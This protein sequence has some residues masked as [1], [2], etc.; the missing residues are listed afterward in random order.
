MKQFDLAIVGAGAAGMMAAITASEAGKRV[1]LID[2]NPQI[3]RKVL[4]TG[5][6]RCNLTNRFVDVHRY[7]G[8]SPEFIDT[9]LRRF[10]QSAT[11][12]FFENL[13]LV[14]KEEDNGRIFP[15][16]NQAS[17]VV[18]AMRLRLM[19]LGVTLIL[20]AQVVGIAPSQGWDVSF[21]DGDRIH[22]HN[23]ILATGGRAAH[24][25]GSTGDGL[26]WAQKL[27]H[28]LTP[29]FPALVPVETLETWPKEVQGIK[30]S[31]R[32]SATSDAVS[33]GE[34][35]GDMLFTSYGL[36]GPSVMALS[37][38]IAP[39]L[40]ESAA[41]IHIDLLPEFDARAL[42]ELLIRLLACRGKTTAESLIGLLPQNLIPIVLRVANVDG[43]HRS[44]EV[45]RHDRAR[46]A[47][48][49]KD[50]ILTPSKLRPLKE[51]QVTAGGVSAEEIDPE[52]LQSRLVPNLFFAGEIVDVDGDSGG[53]NLQWAWSSGRIA[54]L[55]CE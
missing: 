43:N 5:N 31:A 50:L 37:R 4:A 55:L 21:K 53:F 45:P 19:D 9:V 32:V 44:C 16:T 54:G 41:R 6:G 48:I 1:A 28:T 10:D 30:V 14:L 23:L 36:S 38:G 2:R 12:D 13:G 49:L 52:T 25:L 40:K 39:F 15:R 24:Y 20:D 11:M 17:S 27:G 33:T 29:I 7:H 47:A 34:S 26:Y 51:A 18:E 35:S 46:I 3:G 22:S 42:D 8:A